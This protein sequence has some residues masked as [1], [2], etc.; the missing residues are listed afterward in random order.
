MANWSVGCDKAET[1]YLFRLVVDCC[2]VHN[3]EQVEVELNPFTA[4]PVKA[5]N[6][7]IAYWSKPPFLIFD[8]RAL[9]R[10]VLSARAPEC[11]KF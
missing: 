2:G 11:Q 5:S 7:A 8:I 3:T 6:F 9:W 4:D 1:L 10:L